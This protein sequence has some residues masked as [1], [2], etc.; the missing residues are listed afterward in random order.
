MKTLF[1]NY[2]PSSELWQIAIC[3]SDKSET[4]REENE[5]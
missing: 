5:S 4:N 2:P 3:N 1:G